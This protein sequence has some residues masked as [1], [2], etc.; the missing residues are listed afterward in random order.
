MDNVIL[1]EN[2][3]KYLMLFNAIDEGFVIIDVIFNEDDEPNDYCFLEANPAFIK[4]TRLENAMGRT[5]KELA[6][7]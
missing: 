5:M 4:Q 1:S 2:E 3:T 7:E 6:P